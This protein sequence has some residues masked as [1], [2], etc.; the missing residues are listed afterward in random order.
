MKVSPLAWFFTFKIILAPEVTC[1]SIAVLGLAFPFLQK[2]WCWDND[3]DY[4][5]FVDPLG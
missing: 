1:N 3:R 2:E 5:E 4:T